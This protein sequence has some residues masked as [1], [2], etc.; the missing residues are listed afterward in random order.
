M[1]VK[2]TYPH[3]ER[4]KKG[5]FRYTREEFDRSLRNACGL[6]PEDLPKRDRI[7]RGKKIVKQQKAVQSDAFDP[8]VAGDPCHRVDRRVRK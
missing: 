5:R 6:I 4:R 8:C 3:V 2:V 1:E 7:K